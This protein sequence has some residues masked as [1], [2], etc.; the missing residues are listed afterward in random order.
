[1]CC[2]CLGVYIRVASGDHTLQGWTLYHLCLSLKL[3]REV[4][5]NVQVAEVCVHSGHSAVGCRENT[6]LR[7][8]YHSPLLGLSFISE[9]GIRLEM[10][11]VSFS[12][13]MSAMQTTNAVWHY[14]KAD[15]WVTNNFG[16]CK[17]QSWYSHTISMVRKPHTNPKPVDQGI[18]ALE[19]NAIPFT[20]EPV[21]GGSR[22]ARPTQT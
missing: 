4:L 12:P 1:M 14:C 5:A 11:D 7:V 15:Y 20:H 2:F 18:L 8:L 16:S 17:W 9:S 22:P 3:H 21:R 6:R 10:S 13:K 19:A